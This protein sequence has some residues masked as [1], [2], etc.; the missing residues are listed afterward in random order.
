MNVLQNAF[1][2]TPAGGTVT[3]G[4]HAH[5]GRLLIEVHDECGGIPE[6]KRDLFQPFGDRRGTDR[7]GLGLGLAIARQAVRANAGDVHVRNMPGKGCIFTIDLALAARREN[8]P[9]TV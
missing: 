8:V 7:S 3:L 5:A 1:K 4:A 9:Q 2:Y 6:P